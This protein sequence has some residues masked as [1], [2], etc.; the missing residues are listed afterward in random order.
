MERCQTGKRLWGQVL[1]IVPEGRAA[2]RWWQWSPACYAFAVAAGGVGVLHPLMAAL[3]RSTGCP[4]AFARRNRP[5]GWPNRGVRYLLPQGLLSRHDLLALGDE[6]TLVAQ[7]EL[8]AAVPGMAL[9]WHH[10]AMVSAAGA[11]GCAQCCLHFRSCCL[12]CLHVTPV[13]A[14]HPEMAG[15]APQGS[16]IGHGRCYPSM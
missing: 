15:P 2:G 9:H 11:L 8:P 4:G 6:G 1:T 13:P 5:S 10:E 14:N 16:Y 12:L 7:A 3:L